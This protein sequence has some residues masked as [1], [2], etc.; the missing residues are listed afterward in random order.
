MR[1]RC[2]TIDVE[3]RTKNLNPNRWHVTNQ[4]HQVGDVGRHVFIR[5]GNKSTMKVIAD[6]IL[7]GHE[8]CQEGSKWP[9]NGRYTAHE[10][11]D[12]DE[13]KVGT[14]SLKTGKFIGSSEKL[15]QL[16]LRLGDETF[17]NGKTQPV[18]GLR[19]SG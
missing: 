11:A 9:K 17:D 6:F 14:H 19:W 1:L 16:I 2:I 7:M 12:T 13:L 5:E 8:T 15:F 10:V 3:G 4:I 18:D